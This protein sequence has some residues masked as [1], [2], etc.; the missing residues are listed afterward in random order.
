ML[1][2]NELLHLQ[3]VSPRFIGKGSIRPEIMRLG[4]P[5]DRGT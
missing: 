3:T 1:A 5:G 2:R 4:V